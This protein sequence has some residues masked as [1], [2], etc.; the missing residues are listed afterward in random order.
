VLVVRRG[1]TARSGAAGAAAGGDMWP[2]AGGFVAARGLREGQRVGARAQTSAGVVSWRRGAVVFAT[3]LAGLPCLGLPSCAPH[4]GVP[5][6]FGWWLMGGGVGG[7]GGRCRFTGGGDADEDGTE[8]GEQ[9]VVVGKQRN[10]TWQPI[11]GGHGVC[12]CHV[13]LHTDRVGEVDTSGHK[14]IM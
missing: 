10:S 5:S 9:V 1:V 12:R 6:V 11:D 13:T 2:R 3:H 14:H 4:L 7:S 8:G